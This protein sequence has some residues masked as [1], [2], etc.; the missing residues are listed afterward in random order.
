MRANA[1]SGPVNCPICRGVVARTVSGWMVG[2][3][4]SANSLCVDKGVLVDLLANRSHLEMQRMCRK[5][6]GLR[7]RYKGTSRDVVGEFNN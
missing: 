7:G 3:G 4:A 5:V 1:G 6:D 2:N